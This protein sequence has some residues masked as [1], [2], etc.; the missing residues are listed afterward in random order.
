[1]AVY[2]SSIQLFVAEY[3]AYVFFFFQNSSKST[4][5]N[6]ENLKELRNKLLVLNKS[7]KEMDESLDIDNF[8]VPLNEKRT[9]SI[10]EVLQ[11][12]Y[13]KLSIV[14]DP[15]KIMYNC[16]SFGNKY[17][18]KLSKNTGNYHVLFSKMKTM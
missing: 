9:Y 7:K 15:I 18:K 17:S 4:K 2:Y 11:V 12:K 3:K 8:E 14:I 16:F 6:D 1:M 13:T 10:V 5:N